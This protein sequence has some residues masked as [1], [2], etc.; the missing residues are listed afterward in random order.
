MIGELPNPYEKKFFRIRKRQM[1]VASDI[2]AL[3][4]I[5][6]SSFAW[7]SWKFAISNAIQAGA[8]AC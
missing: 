6:K 5:K 4:V 1:Q 7:W 3:Q 8:N 2:L